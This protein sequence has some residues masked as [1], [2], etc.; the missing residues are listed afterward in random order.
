[1]IRI[2]IDMKNTENKP[3]AISAWRVAAKRT[4]TTTKHKPK[5][6]KTIAAKKGKAITKAAYGRAARRT[7]T[8]SGK[9]PR[10]LSKKPAKKGV[11]VTRKAY[12]RAAKRIILKR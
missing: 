1:M 3:S 5:P 4:V 11:E 10:M 12:S 9:G 7:V 6:R 2:H 8:P